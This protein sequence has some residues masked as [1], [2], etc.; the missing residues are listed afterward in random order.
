MAVTIQIDRMVLIWSS[1]KRYLGYET[2]FIDELY[3]EI[4]QKIEI[5]T[6]Q[7]VKA[8]REVTIPNTMKEIFSWE[9]GIDNYVRRRL[10]PTMK[11]SRQLP[12]SLV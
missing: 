11:A 10:S 8:G 9:K 2:V 5:N 12:E 4:A 1:P 6:K 7:M 3:C